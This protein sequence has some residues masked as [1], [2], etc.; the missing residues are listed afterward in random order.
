MLGKGDYL[1]RDNGWCKTG[2]VEDFISYLEK[3]E[4]GIML[5]GV[6]EDYSGTYYYAFGL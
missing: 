1:S 6:Y 2:S 4:G 5:E 3:A